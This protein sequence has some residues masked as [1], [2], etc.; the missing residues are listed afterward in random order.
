MFFEV[1]KIL[2][3]KK[4]VNLNFDLLNAPIKYDFSSVDIFPEKIRAWEL[5]EIGFTDRTKNI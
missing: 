5:I 4:D 2:K 1:F 3:S